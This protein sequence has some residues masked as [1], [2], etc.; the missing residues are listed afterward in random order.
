MEDDVGG[1]PRLGRKP[2]LQDIGR[3]LRRGVPRRELVLEVRPHQLGNHR[4][5]DDGQDPQ[6]QHHPAAVV[7]GA[8]Q[9]PQDGFGLLGR[10]ILPIPATH[11]RFTTKIH[12]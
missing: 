10:L 5:G 12:H 6:R 1:V 7:T 11:D 3:L 4:E 9:A 8:G 2:L